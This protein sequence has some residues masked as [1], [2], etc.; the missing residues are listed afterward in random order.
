MASASHMTLLSR[1]ALLATRLVNG[2]VRKLGRGQ[3]T[4]LGGRVGLAI[5]GDLIARASRTRPV[6]LVSGTNGKTTTTALLAA[7][8]SRGYGSVVTNTTGS[9][10][11]SGHV[12]AL[13]QGPRSAPIVLEVDEAYLA[14]TVHSTTA[15]VVVLL[16]LSRDQLD[17]SNEVRKTVARW[18]EGLVGASTVIV[19]NG[20]DPLV[21]AAVNEHPRVIWVAAGASWRLDAAAC[22][23][24]RGHIDYA[25][26]GLQW[27]CSCGFARPSITWSFHQETDLVTLEGR[28]DISVAFHC[29]LPGRF[30]SSNAAMALVGAHELGVSFDDARSGVEGVR[31]VAGRFANKS[32]GGMAVRALLAKNPAGWAELLE[33]I[34]ERDRALVVAI[35]SRVA[36]GHDPSWLWD[37][38]FERLVGRNVVASGERC[39]DL[40]V[41][42]HYAGVA[43]HTE[44]D[45]REALKIASEIDPGKEIDVIGNYTAFH[46]L[47]GLS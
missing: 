29:A 7:A 13:S 16:N 4:V 35:N 21:V 25:E 33:L 6:A 31:G 36:D 44:R 3:G 11:S 45:L 32:I 1:S 2:S 41:R 12:A 5:T 42:L 47:L 43:H 40:G 8:V 30:N 27:S 28:D 24:C 15:T 37:V 34:N 39:Y 10:M 17:R 26:T 38:P 9:N 20:D 18:R 22:P 46:D 14:R 23:L 19:A